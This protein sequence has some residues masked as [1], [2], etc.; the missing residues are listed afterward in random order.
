MKLLRW[1]L[2]ILAACSETQDP[3]QICGLEIEGRERWIDAKQPGVGASPA[4]M[5]FSARGK[6][7]TILAVPRCHY[8]IDEIV[9]TMGPNNWVV[10]AKSLGFTDY[11][12]SD[13]TPEP[14]G[15]FTV[16]HNRK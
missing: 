5:G 8:G 10:Q 4:D 1:C 7:K 9:R 2:V 3:R 16:P 15:N 11:Q 13:T 12:C 6:C 14:I